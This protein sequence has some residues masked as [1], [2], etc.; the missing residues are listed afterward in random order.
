MSNNDDNQETALTEFSRR[1]TDEWL[2]VYCNDPKRIEHHTVEGFKWE[3]VKVS[4]MDASDFMRS[5]DNKI[6]V[7][8]GGGRFRMSQSK[9]N[10]YMFTHGSNAITPRPLTLWLEPVITIGVMARLHMD[11]GW[12]LACLGMQS[13][14]WAFDFVVFNPHDLVNEYIAGEVKKTEKELDT[15]IANLHK[16]CDE[17][18]IDIKSL[19]AAR[20]N[21]HKK[22]LGLRRCHAPLFWALGPNGY[23]HIFKVNYSPDGDITLHKTTDDQ[24]YYSAA[25]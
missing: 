16:S 14:G 8:T 15:F 20:I 10:E 6:V 1:I 2:P 7:D 12:P 9:A 17:G 3:S 22:W 24:L 4:A 25:T 19:S 18:D 11:Y 23:G 21:A 5:L 13:E